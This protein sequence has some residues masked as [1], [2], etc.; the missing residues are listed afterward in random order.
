MA[1]KSQAHKAWLFSFFFQYSDTN[2]RRVLPHLSGKKHSLK[3]TLMQSLRLFLSE[4]FDLQSDFLIFLDLKYKTPAQCQG[5]LLKL[6]EKLC[7]SLSRRKEPGT[8]F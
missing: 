8:F 4:R 3:D 1:Y 6:V 5:F 2:S 7:D